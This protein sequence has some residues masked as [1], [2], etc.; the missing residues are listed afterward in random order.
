M[1]DCAQRLQTEECHP[2]YPRRVQSKGLRT[3]RTC[4][5]GDLHGGCDHTSVIIGSHHQSSPDID[6]Q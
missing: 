1:N 6:H 4:G 5:T 3:E 2:L